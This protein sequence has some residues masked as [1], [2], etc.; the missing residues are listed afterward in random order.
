M[1]K[2][3]PALQK[4]L[5]HLLRSNRSTSGLPDKFPL[6]FPPHSQPS[7]PPGHLLSV[8]Q[9]IS[10]VSDQASSTVVNVISANG[11]TTSSNLLATDKPSS[12]SKSVNN[13]GESIPIKVFNPSK[14]RESKTYMLKLNPAVNNLQLL[15]EEILEQLGK[16]V[17]KYDLS[18]DVGYFSGSH[19]IIFTEADKIRTELNHLTSKNKSLW[20]EGKSK[21]LHSDDFVK[22]DS[23][24]E[25]E[26]PPLKKRKKC[27]A[28]DARVQRVD[29]LANELQEKHGSKYNKM[30]YKLWAE[31][32]DVDGHASKEVP[33]LGPIWNTSKS[34]KSGTKDSVNEM[35]SAFTNMANTVATAFQP[36]QD[37]PTRDVLNPIQPSSAGISPGKRIDLQ[38]KLFNQLDLLHKIFERGALNVDQY[39]KRRDSLL[40]QMDNLK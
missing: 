9:S 13:E 8:S 23:D 39:E 27:S 34:Q 10:K 22:I 12:S 7:N 5:L 4:T 2:M 35:A 28:F 37:T 21:T 38:Q 40:A 1:Q 32:L 15:R 17:V 36:S 33:P 26:P 14:K 20:C 30:Q 25:D 6:L 3:D 29:S 16:G 11:G 19:K 24:S 18:F 31:A